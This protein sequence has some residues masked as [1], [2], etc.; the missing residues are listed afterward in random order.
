MAHGV[1]KPRK[2]N[3]GREITKGN[4]TK[5]GHRDE[6]QRMM[7]REELK[8]QGFAL[9]NKVIRVKWLTVSTLSKWSTFWW[10]QNTRTTS[11]IDNS[12]CLCH[13]K[14]VI[15]KVSWNQWSTWWA[16]GN[17]KKEKALVF[18]GFFASRICFLLNNLYTIQET[19]MHIVQCV[20]YLFFAG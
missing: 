10:Q 20:S 15:Q 11:A 19:K 7:D 16:P 5:R 17:P 8:E 14:L 2:N 1:W 6:F 9:S 18:Q 4:N 12:W 3:T 13:K